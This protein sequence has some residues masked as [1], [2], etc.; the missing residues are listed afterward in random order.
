VPAKRMPRFKTGKAL[1]KPV[2]S[3]GGRASREMQAVPIVVGR[4]RAIAE[5]RR[6]GDAGQTRN[7]R[8]PIC[9]PYGWP[10]QPQEKRL[11]SVAAPALLPD[12]G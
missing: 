1:G 2:N 7:R 9:V 3:R 6:K 5:R 8:E 11:A 12:G 4:C 10:V